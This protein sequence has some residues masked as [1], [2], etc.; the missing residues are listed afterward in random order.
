MPETESTVEE[1]AT[2]PIRPPRGLHTNATMKSALSQKTRY[3]LPNGSTA[4]VL[5]NGAFITDPK[6]LPTDAEIDEHRKDVVA[7]RSR[8]S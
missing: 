3:V 6:E 4:S 2:K 5:F 8:I 1:S 7:R